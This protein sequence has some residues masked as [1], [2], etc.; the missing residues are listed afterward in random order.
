MSEARPE[1]HDGRRQDSQ[2]GVVLPN[3]CRVFHEISRVK[4]SV[5]VVG[6]LTTAWSL[7]HGPS[8][9]VGY[10]FYRVC[11]TFQRGPLYHHRVY[12]RWA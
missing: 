12:R 4:G 2:D 11:G 8:S 6:G 7:L 1:K 3:L 9:V 5:C 10:R